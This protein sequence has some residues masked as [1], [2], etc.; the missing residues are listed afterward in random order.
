M[1]RRQNATFYNVL[2]PIWIL[3]WL[4]SLWWLLLI[5]LN[6]ILDYCVL[7]KSLPCSAQRLAFC[8][9]HAWKICAAGFASDFLGSLFLLGVLMVP[10]SQDWE[11][12]R[13]IQNGI[14][15]NPFSGWGSFFIVAAAILLS[16]VCIYWLDAHLLKRTGLSTEQ[17]R[18]SARWLAALTAPYLF[19]LPS[20]ILYG[21]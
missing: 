15:F 9:K 18:T 2:F 1:L 21:F 12:L 11:L 17:C 20:E 4:P 6:F 5:P 13:N 3:V 16:A 7:Y 10:H 14:S 19:L 8:N